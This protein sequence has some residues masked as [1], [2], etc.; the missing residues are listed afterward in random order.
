MKILLAIQAT[1]NGHISRAQ[2][3]YP[4]LQKYGEVDQSFTENPDDLINNI[5]DLVV[6]LSGDITN[7]LVYLPR[8]MEY[9]KSI[10]IADKILLSDHAELIFSKA[11]ENNVRVLIGSCVS[12]SLPI[13]ISKNSPYYDG[14]DCK[15][16]RGNGST[17][18][19]SAILED[20]FYFYFLYYYCSQI[21]LMLKT[22]QKKLQILHRYA[23]PLNLVS[24]VQ[25]Q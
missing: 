1:G 6:D 24:I 19:S 13:N 25:R 11:R 5:S 20:I 15:E 12:S 22:S 18:V 4:I 9:K 2:A 8:L 3:I 23:S 14:S 21:V 16:V 10:L 17:E 7:S